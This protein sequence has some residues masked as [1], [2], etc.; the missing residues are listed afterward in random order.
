MPMNN[1][2]PCAILDHVVFM[3]DD[4]VH[5]GQFTQDKIGLI[6]MSNHGK[7]HENDSLFS[8]WGVVKFCGPDCKIVK[9]GDHVVIEK[10]KWTIGFK[11]NGVE[12]WRTSEPHI[13]AIEDV[14]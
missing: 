13:I 14:E 6:Q 9:E 12:Y 4:G 11:V 1:E 8:R 10:H 7:S 5:D 2:I 3:F